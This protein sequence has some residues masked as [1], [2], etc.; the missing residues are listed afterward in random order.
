M[1]IRVRKST[2]P[3]SFF[4]RAILDIFMVLLLK[5]TTRSCPAFRGKGLRV[6]EFLPKSKAAECHSDTQ[7][8]VFP[9]YG[10]DKI[11][12]AAHLNPECDFC[13]QS[14]SLPWQRRTSKLFTTS[15]PAIT[16][17]IAKDTP[18]KR[19]MP[20]KSQSLCE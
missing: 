15:Q 20:S 18:T 11:F 9:D 4:I 3:N 13:H 1:L 14:D 12:Q 19:Q 2:S 8:L 5:S 10:L 7:P 17:I 6:R 16:T